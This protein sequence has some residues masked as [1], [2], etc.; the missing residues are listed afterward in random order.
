MDVSM[1]F[2]FLLLN[3][4]VNCKLYTRRVLLFL[5]LS[6]NVYTETVYDI[7]MQNSLRSITSISNGFKLFILRSFGLRHREVW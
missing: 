4:P 1:S 6:F 3:A 2:M 5:L 7:K